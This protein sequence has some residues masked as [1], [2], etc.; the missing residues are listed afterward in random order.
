MMIDGAWLMDVGKVWNLGRPVPVPAV[1]VLFGV[2]ALGYAL[3]L[4]AFTRRD[5][6]APL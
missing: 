6:P 5:L 1:G 3:A 4:R 2:G